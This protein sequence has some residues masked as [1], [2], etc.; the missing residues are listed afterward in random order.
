MKAPF[1]NPVRLAGKRGKS[2]GSM[3]ALTAYFVYGVRAASAQQVM[4]RHMPASPPRGKTFILGCGKA[5]AAMAQVARGH[6]SGEVIG[7]VVTRYGHGVDQDIDGV[8]V[9]EARHP[10]PDAAGRAAAEEIIALAHTAGPDDRV[11][12]VI[13][14]G[15]SALL[16]APAIGLELEEKQAITDH[17]VR[18]GA[19]IEDINLVRRHLSRVKGGRLGAI[20]G[21][22]GAQL[23]TLVISDVVGDDPALVASGPSVAAPFEPDRAIA[24]LERYGWRPGAALAHA[25]RANRP[26]DVP[27][28]E[29]VTLA[30]G[31]TALDAVAARARQDGWNVVDLGHA[32]TGEASA[33]GAAHAVLAQELLGK[34]GRHLVLSGGELTVTSVGKHGCGGPNLEYLAGLAQVLRPDDPIC[35]LAGDSD[36]IDGTQD[37]AG[38]FVTAGTIPADALCA[39]LASHRTYALFQAHGGLIL[40]GP[41]LTNVN[42]IR[43]IAVEP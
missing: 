24:T 5:A 43:M 6:T 12:F 35:A 36:G 7:C 27:G 13:S 8:R 17:L 29:V 37:N 38:G 1:E 25:I 19:P 15:G 40:T 28:H 32:L 26:D 39:A 4:P 10:V 9:I 31:R 3:D 21:A 14:G 20:A 18:S 33:V 2:M 22:R 16:C 41:S 30:T 34:P 11:I 42:D 23:L